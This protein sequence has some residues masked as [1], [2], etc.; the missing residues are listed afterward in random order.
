MYKLYTFFRFSFFGVQN[1]ALKLYTFFQ[2]FIFGVQICT[3][4]GARQGSFLELV[5]H[6]FVTIECGHE[7]RFGLAVVVDV[8]AVQLL[9]FGDEH[10]L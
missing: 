1:L 8:G 7:Y 2:I 4:Y 10:L 3:L 5:G 6:H 9:L